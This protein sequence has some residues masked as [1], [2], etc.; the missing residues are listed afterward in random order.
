MKKLFPVFFILL[1]TISACKPL[2]VR[3]GLKQLDSLM[4]QLNETRVML[5]TLDTISVQFRYSQYTESIKKIN[6]IT[7]DNFGK[8]ELL[9]LGQYGQIRKPLKNFTMSMKGFYSEADYSFS[10]LE[11]LRFDLEKKLISSEKFDEHYAKEKDA[12]Q[13]FM[14]QFRILYEEA[15]SQLNAFDTLYPKVLVIIDKHSNK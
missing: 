10:Q 15:M 4:T 1:F 5:N 3:H 2:Y 13:N 11:N 12:V 7:D 9:V 8:D 14:N 6:S